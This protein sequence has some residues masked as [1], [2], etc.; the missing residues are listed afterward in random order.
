M[1]EQ[2]TVVHNVKTAARTGIILDS[3]ASYCNTELS[4]PL[5]V[6]PIGFQ[7]LNLVS[8]R[9]RGVEEEA[10]TATDLNQSS[11]GTMSCYPSGLEFSWQGVKLI[12]VELLR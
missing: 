5:V 7:P 1:C 2:V 4:Q 3:F 6:S 12:R 10:C 8:E 11:T 9:T